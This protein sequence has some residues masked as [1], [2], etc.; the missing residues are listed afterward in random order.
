MITQK[1]YDKL[2][3]AFEKYIESVKIKIPFALLLSHGYS[4]DDRKEWK[5]LMKEFHQTGNKGR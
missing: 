5:K 3:K 1:E 4:L 2:W